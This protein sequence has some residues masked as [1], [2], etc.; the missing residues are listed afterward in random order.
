MRGRGAVPEAAITSV[1]MGLPCGPV[2]K[3][4]DGI[5]LIGGL[6]LPEGEVSPAEELPPERRLMSMVIVS[7]VHGWSWINYRRGE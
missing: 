1:G 5:E 2:R 6:S 3:A 4:L 7:Q